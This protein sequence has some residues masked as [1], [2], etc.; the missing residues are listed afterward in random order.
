MGKMNFKI[1]AENKNNASTMFKGES[2]RGDRIKNFLKTGVMLI[3]KV[4]MWQIL[5]NCIT[6]RLPANE[7]LDFFNATGTIGFYGKKVGTIN[8]LIKLNLWN[9]KITCY[10]M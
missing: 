4:I 5:Q 9:K 8:L 6:L 10:F 1:L 7:T 3:L 2:K